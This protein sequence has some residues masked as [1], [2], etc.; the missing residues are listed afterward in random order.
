MTGVGTRVGDRPVLFLGLMPLKKGQLVAT[1]ATEVYSALAPSLQQG[2]ASF[3]PHDP[4]WRL[5]VADNDPEATNNLL[6]NLQDARI[7]DRTL[8]DFVQYDGISM[9]QFLPSYV[10]PAFY[11]AVELIR[12][13]TE[14]VAEVNPREI[15]AFPADDATD[16]LWHGALLAVGQATGVSVTF[17][18]KPWRQFLRGVPRQMRGLLRQTGFG[19]W[20]IRLQR[21]AFANVARWL[22]KPGRPVQSSAG[23]RLLFCTV[24]KHWVSVPGVP[25]QRYDEQV[26][27]LLPALRARGWTTFI[28]VDCPYSSYTAVVR[29]LWERLRYRESG[30]TWRSFYSYPNQDRAA[31][32]KASR[33]F[34]SQWRELSRDPTFAQDFRY[35]GVSL[36]PALNAELEHSFFRILPE[37]AD[38]LDRA[39]HILALDSPD[40]VV[41]TYET[42]PFQRALLI[43]CARAGIPTLGLQHGMIFDNHYDYMHRRVTSELLPG[44][45]VPKVTCVWG[46]FWQHV[47]TQAGHYPPQSVVAT[48]NWRYDRIALVNQALDRAQIKR[49]FGISPEKRVVLILS[50]N[51][52]TT[53]YVRCCLELLSERRECAPLVKLHPTD[54]PEPIRELLRQMCLPPTTLIHDHL[55]EALTVSDL[56]ISQASTVISEAVLFDNPIVMVDFKNLKGWDA[57]S[58]SGVCLRATTPG[59][60]AVALEQGL[61]DPI[62]LERLSRARPR[63]VQEYFFKL[64][65]A[66]AQRVAETLERLIQPPDQDSGGRQ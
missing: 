18:R 43:Q 16:P 20:L 62:A 60:L 52:D 5:H 24:A 14:L 31:Y 53:G 49:A 22:A 33:V 28:G 57:Y 37:C 11:R 50:A 39:G 46:S 44:F 13:L 19:R 26:F 6:N 38:M 41:A 58:E 3:Q 61:N 59:E 42:G 15:C 47:L 55:F 35:H 36:M 64:D 45:T 32:R 25:D 17:T 56:V 30:V 4:A 23:K 12:L 63:F 51:Q 29:K 21:T 8:L 27:P 40:A 66:S 2:P 7:A 48:G 9:W 1:A 65:G 34:R 54:D 10:W